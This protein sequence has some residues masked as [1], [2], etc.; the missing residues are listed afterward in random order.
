MWNSKFKMIPKEY[1]ECKYTLRD[2]LTFFTEKLNHRCLADVEHV[3]NSCIISSG[4]VIGWGCIN[5]QLNR[6]W[7]INHGTIIH[8]HYNHIVDCNWHCTVNGVI[9]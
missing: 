5:I 6:G 2:V 8:S 9:L 3:S 4:K 7:S 1:R